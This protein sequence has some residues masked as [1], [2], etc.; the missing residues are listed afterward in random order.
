MTQPRRPRPVHHLAAASLLSMGLS[1][2]LAPSAVAQ[3]SPAD[4]QATPVRVVRATPP[5]PIRRAPVQTQS[6]HVKATIRD[7]VATTTIRQKL[8]NP[9][10]TIAEADWILPLPHGSVA[11]GFTMTMG[12]ETVPGE[13]LSAD[14][15]RSIYEAIVRRRRDP[16]LLEY[17]GTGCLRAR[18]FPIPAQGDV[19]VEVRYRQ[20]LSAT[21]G[22]FDWRFPLRAI[23]NLGQ[24]KLTVELEIDSQRPIKS[25]YS[26]LTDVGVSRKD[27]HHAKASLELPAGAIPSR[28]LEIYY[29][30]DTRSFGLDLLTWKKL[31]ADPEGYALLMVTPKHDWAEDKS[32]RRCVQFVV[33]TSGSMKGE[34]IAQAREALRFFVQSMR[35]T[36][37]FDV[38]P[39]STE[40]RPFYGCPTA[41]TPE[42]VADALGKIAELQAVGGTNIEDGLRTALAADLPKLR[43]HAE[44][45][46]ITV[47]LTDGQP[48]LGTTDPDAL[49]GLINKNNTNSDRVFVFGVGNDV[50]TRLLDRVAEQNRGDRDYVRP[51][52]NIEVKTSALF[53]KISHPVLTDLELS[54][55]G[56]LELVDRSPKV[57]PDLFK[58]SQLLVLAKYRGGS[59]NHA[60]RLRGKIGGTAQELVYEGVFTKEDT[61]HD[62]VPVLWAERRIAVLLEAI[63]LHGRSQELIDEVTRIGKEFGVV[64]PFTS[65]LVVEEGMRVAADRGIEPN[66]QGDTFFMGSG[67]QTAMEIEG[68]LQTLTEELRRAGRA[69]GAEI[70]SVRDRL[71]RVKADAEAAERA[72]ADLDSSEVTGESAVAKSLALRSI[73]TRAGTPSAPNAGGPSTPG[74]GGPAAGGGGGSAPGQSVGGF[75]GGLPATNLTVMRV[76]TRTFHLAGGAWID[77]SFEAKHKGKERVVHA[78]SKEYFELLAANPDLKA[79][80]A[81]STNI[82]VV[83]QDGSVVEVK[84]APAK[85]EHPTPPAPGEPGTSKD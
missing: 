34:K 24:A 37:L 2:A 85:A 80:L 14:K 79:C 54:V 60:V 72:L 22:I 10:N 52:E 56:D 40:A 47:F 74:A 21:S 82:V 64:T 44:I 12:N 35:P 55:D 15:A 19:V 25:V 70:G 7:G 38:V 78:F 53:T 65:Q 83:L 69:P 75:G 11:D 8:H 17:Y 59:G 5:R 61:K 42:R 48:T 43:D 18:V 50:N 71:G 4:P 45:V 3:I 46:R 58:G 73:A 51:G 28:D 36:D 49:L 32:T 6:V 23:D 1:A 9:T 33:D 20:V 16:G 39:F 27:D 76:G 81:F 57:L 29:S 66:A 63:R 62:F 13:V 31:A 41:A 67:R 84:P 30:T 26:P 68:R 77:R